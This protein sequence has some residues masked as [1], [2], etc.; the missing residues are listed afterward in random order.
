MT[1]QHQTDQST[2]PDQPPTTPQQPASTPSPQSPPPKRS[3]FGGKVFKIILA[4][5]L[6]IVIIGFTLPTT[7]NA[8]TT[9]IFNTTPDKIFPHL[10]NLKRW[11]E[12]TV[13]NTKTYPNLKYTFEGPE[14]GIGAI[15]SYKDDSMGYP[16][17]TQITESLKNKS[18]RYTLT[19]GDLPS[20][21][22]ITLTSSPNDPNKTTVS[23]SLDMNSG[24]NI[25]GRYA[26][27]L[28]QLNIRVSQM[29]NDSLNELKSQIEP[30]NED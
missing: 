27:A 14:S 30:K 8:S 9:V 20:K 10:N 17:Q 23:W 4:L 18:I 5:I 15:M 12:W 11:P 2:P 22:H 3:S 13:W 29:F 16:G 24:S 1:S 7:Y 25:F 6:L 19:I 28:A 21:G 26:F